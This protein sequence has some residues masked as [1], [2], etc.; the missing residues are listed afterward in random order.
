M[1]RH[2]GMDVHK[3]TVQVCI[4]GRDGEV[5][6]TR[7]PCTREQIGRFAQHRLEPDDQIAL[8]A[9]TNTW[10]VVDILKRYVQKVTVSNPML[11]RAIASAKIKTDK[12]DALVLARLLRSG[13]LPTVWE[14]DEQTRQIRREMSIHSAL[15]A[16]RTRL[17]NR[18]HSVLAGSLIP[19]PVA[20]L[21]SL[22]G[23]DWL[24][25][26]A[27]P[28][29]GVRIEVDR[30]MRQLQ[31][32]EQ[33]I[34]AHHQLL[35]KKAYEDDRV[36]LLM[37]LPGVNYPVA[38]SLISALGDIN[39]FP[40]PDRAASYL[41]L[42]PSTHGSADKVYHGPITKRGRSHSRWMLVQAAQHLAD[43]PGPLG[44]FFRRLAARK[45]RNVAVVATA[46]KLVTIAWHMLRNNEPYRYAQPLP[47]QNKLSTLRVCATGVRRKTGPAKGQP[48]PAS[49]APGQRTRLRPELNALY[50]SE[51][52]PP[53][54]TI[55][56]LP[57]GERRL[58]QRTRTETYVDSLRAEARLPRKNKALDGNAQ[59]S[60]DPEKP[61]APQGRE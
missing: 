49:H 16:D 5:V 29:E 48:R 36:R 34:G 46:R 43:H 27:F 4:L 53:S 6:Q 60:A 2:V 8:E 61:R 11:T 19:V 38:L 55:D 51:G 59:T 56:T 35:A 54:R 40:D 41:G 42:V 45:N 1:V 37:T 18:I 15:V 10:G 9:T 31:T 47:T 13:Y 7:I 3:K 22:K 17:K 14:P 26:A 20:D 12:I 21:F 32:T 39:R 28:E 50:S 44:H 25:S 33:E 30:W 23:R 57:A 24:G 58:L 52:L